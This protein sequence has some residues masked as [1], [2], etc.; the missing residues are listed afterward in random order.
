MID[1]VIAAGHEGGVRNSGATGS[2]KTWGTAGI[3]GGPAERDLTPLIADAATVALRDAGFTVERSSAFYRDKLK[4]KLAVA[5]HLDGSATRCASGASIGYPIGRPAGSNKPAA[6]AWRDI[7]STVWPFKW[8]PDNFTKNLSGYYGYAWTS[9]TDAELVLELG[10]LT[11]PDQ[12][13]WLVP[14]IESGWL[15]K[16]VAHWIAQRLGD[17]DGLVPMPAPFD[18]APATVAIAPVLDAI[19]GIEAMAG[20][21]LAATKAATAA[22][23]KAVDRAAGLEA[24][25][26]EAR[27]WL[28][29]LEQ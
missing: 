16:V 27:K 24:S 8:M 18:E 9:T 12:H 19:A 20:S 14:R 29:G 21:A 23:A 2:T 1:V 15:G 5:V 10:E 25:V 13:A 11:C 28:E 6:D 26:L 3:P 17:P 7:Y 4:C 22:S